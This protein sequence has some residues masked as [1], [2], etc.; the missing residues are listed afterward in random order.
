MFEDT[1]PAAPRSSPPQ[2]LPLEPEDILAA[3]EG[4]AAPAVT[5]PERPDALEAGKL[6][7]KV[8]E[9]SALGAELLPKAEGNIAVLPEEY[10]T[11]GPIIGKVVM[12]VLAV[13]FVGIVAWGG[14][15]MWKKRAAPAIEPAPA[16]AP[17]GATLPALSPVTST[18]AEDVR[19]MEN[20]SL[21]FGEPRDTDRD[22]LDDVREGERGTGVNNPDSDNDGLLDGEEVVTFRTDPLNVDTDSDGLPDRS[23]TKVWNTDPL[24]PDSD[25][26]GHSDGKEIYNAFNPLGA[27][28]LVNL[29]PGV[30]TATLRQSVIATTTNRR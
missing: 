11:R 18:N 25:S 21:L 9:A 3:V 20:D 6:K 10:A 30:T 28:K 1:P 7:K 17:A 26:D 15:W 22:G 16:V 2:N 8:A 27:G 13:L 5:A 29:P 23:E 4:A 24:N 14:W 19:Q 12:G